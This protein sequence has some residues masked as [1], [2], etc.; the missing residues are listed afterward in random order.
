MSRGVV[1]PLVAAMTAAIACQHGTIAARPL[2]GRSPRIAAERT[3]LQYPQGGYQLRQEPVP[4]AT[5]N[6][7]MA[8]RQ[9]QVAFAAQHGGNPA[10]A[11]YDSFA[12]G[13]YDPGYGT[14]GAGGGSRIAQHEPLRLSNA[15]KKIL[16]HIA[17]HHAKVHER[18]PDFYYIA[19]FFILIGA[20]ICLYFVRA[21]DD[22]KRQAMTRI[23][24]VRNAEGDR[25]R[26]ALRA[27]EVGEQA[28]SW[29]EMSH[30]IQRGKAA[31]EEE[32]RAEFEVREREMRQEFIRDR[33]EIMREHKARENEL[34]TQIAR[35]R[36]QE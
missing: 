34:L 30:L 15:H 33:N 16:K 28:D 32:L 12:F 24:R 23:A 4:G 35:H 26:L 8:Q 7:L 36:V 31:R 19:A 29:K 22:L 14:A 10:A 25:D 9:P 11:S 6:G 27:R 2:L 18:N 1:L 21:Y 5:G 3:V 17:A 20:P 13:N